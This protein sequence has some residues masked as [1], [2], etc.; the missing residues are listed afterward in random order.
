M[1]KKVKPEKKKVE[2]INSVDLISNKIKETNII[3]PN[4]NDI[5]EVADKIIKK[6]VGKEE[7]P[8][9]VYQGGTTE[10]IKNKKHKKFTWQKIIFDLNKKGLLP[11]TLA[12][13]GP[14]SEGFND[15]LATNWVSPQK[16][17]KKKKSEGLFSKIAESNVESTDFV[18]VLP[19]QK[20]Q[21]VGGEEFGDK[22]EAKAGQLFG[23]GS[24][25]NVQYTID[26]LKELKKQGKLPKSIVLMGHSRGGAN[27]LRNAYEIYKVFG[28]E[29]EVK[30]ILLDPVPGDPA[31]END[32]GRYVIPPNVSSCT[33]FYSEKG[34][35]Q[36]NKLIDPL[37]DLIGFNN[38]PPNKFVLTNPNTVFSSYSTKENHLTIASNNIIRAAVRGLL[39]P[40]SEVAFPE[41]EK[42]LQSLYQD[43]SEMES[44][45]FNFTRWGN[46]YCCEEGPIDKLPEEERN[47]LQ[48]I[49]ERF[50][51]DD[52]GQFKPN[53]KVNYIPEDY[54]KKLSEKE[55]LIKDLEERNNK[56][57]DSQEKAKQRE[58]LL[59]KAYWKTR[60]ITY[61]TSDQTR[62]FWL[63]LIPITLGFPANLYYS[64]KLGNLTNNAFANNV[65]RIGSFIG[66]VLTL[67]TVHSTVLVLSTL[68]KAAF[69]IPRFL[70]IISHD[71]SRLFSIKKRKDKPPVIKIGL[72]DIQVIKEIEEK[73]EEKTKNASVKQKAP[74]VEKLKMPEQKNPENKEDKQKEP[75]I[76]YPDSE[77]NENKKGKQKKSSTFYTD[78]NTAPITSDTLKQENS[79]Y[80]I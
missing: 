52:A 42:S 73:N 14:G 46:K 38:I 64:K 34:K 36:D 43:P 9:I 6:R 29:I 65:L 15:P 54:Q 11:P 41:D 20:M 68:F 4:P 13:D 57:L 2:D 62:D 49:R 19:M 76:L 44:A 63:T 58:E 32:I 66:G 35:Q 1:N 47:Q 31:E 69:Q 8:L 12:M 74:N 78:N 80:K 25:N 28:S 33:V 45:P 77:D 22:L 5:K 70:K 37:V 48:K 39:N 50:R 24:K 61:L 59:R 75:P 18:D 56:P 67:N 23:T 71:L 21:S 72:S 30:L 53:T 17:K 51:G 27:C 10:I 79:E 16:L 3:R 7:D 55:K 60:G 26:V 40:K